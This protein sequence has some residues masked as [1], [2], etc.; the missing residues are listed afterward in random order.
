LFLTGLYGQCG[1]YIRTADKD[2]IIFSDNLNHASIIDGCRLSGAKTIVYKHVDLQDLENKLKEHRNV[3]GL[4][5]TD[6]VFSM[7]GDIAPVPQLAEMAHRYGMLLML[8]CI[9]ESSIS[10]SGT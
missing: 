1:H 7:D 2:W 9:M 3:P 4:I 6:G 8:F 5:V 10:S